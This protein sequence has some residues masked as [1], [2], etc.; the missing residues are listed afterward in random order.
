MSRDEIRGRENLNPIPGEGGSTF[1]VP[2]N[3]GPASAAAEADQ[4]GEELAAREAGKVLLHDTLQRMAKRVC[5]KAQKAIK[6]EEFNTWLRNGMVEESRAVVSDALTPVLDLLEIEGDRAAL[7]V[8][9]FD[10]LRNHYQMILDQE[11]ASTK[12]QLITENSENITN[13]VSRELAIWWMKG[14]KNGS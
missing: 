12:A 3:M 11:S 6:K 2:L 14:N 9:F 8:D 1:M 5:L 4:G 7:I 10:T 13:H